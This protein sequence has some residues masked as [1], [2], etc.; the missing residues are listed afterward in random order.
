M[1]RCL[2]LPVSSTLRPDFLPPHWFPRSL[3]LLH[4]CWNIMIQSVNL[5]L[6]SRS[7]WFVV[8]QRLPSCSETFCQTTPRCFRS[9]TDPALRSSSVCEGRHAPAPSDARL[10]ALLHSFL[11]AHTPSVARRSWLSRATAPHAWPAKLLFS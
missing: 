3:L 8:D 11:C 6:Q 9:N 1:G 7:G 4:S 2:R 5:H 10:N